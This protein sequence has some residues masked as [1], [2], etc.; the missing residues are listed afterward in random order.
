MK[1]WILVLVFLA[2]CASAPPTIQTPEGKR[3]YTANEIV[4]RVHEFQRV[5]I[6]ASDRKIIPE[7]VAREIV[8]WTVASAKTLAS[9]PQGWQGMLRS[10]WLA[11]RERVNSLSQ[12]SHW[13]FVFD[14]MLGVV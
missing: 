1:K 11:V 8:T 9:A 13:S 6:D 4:I 3:A 2:G 14:A 7:E 12:L 10:T 5:V